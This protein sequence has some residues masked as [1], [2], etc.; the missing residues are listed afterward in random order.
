M[1]RGK[2]KTHRIEFDQTGLVISDK[3]QNE[4]ILD[5][6]EE[7]EKTEFEKLQEENDK[8]RTDLNKLIGVK[9]PNYS[10]M[11]VL[12]NGLVKNELQQEEL[13]E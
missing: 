1:D 3:I 4:E 7:K 10:P 11:W 5:V 12:I 2:T 8:I 6:L 9:N 13:C